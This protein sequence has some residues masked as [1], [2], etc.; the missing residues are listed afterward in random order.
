MKILDEALGNKGWQ[1]RYYEVCGTLFCDIGVYDHESKQ[2]IWKSD[3]GSKSDIEGEKGLA[4]DAFKRAAVV[5]GIG[6][7]LYTGPK[8]VIDLTEKDYFN[9]KLCQKFKV[10]ELT[11]T[12]GIITSL[13][14]VDKWGNQRYPTPKAPFQVSQ[15]AIAPPETRRTFTHSGTNP[16]M[17]CFQEFYEKMKKEPNIDLNELERFHVWYTS[18]DK[19]NPSKSKIETFKNPIPERMWENWMKNAR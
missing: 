5:W 14:I 4:S 15:V 13:V 8:P 6:R 7:E 17:A 3:T 11:V 12:D 19:M 9:G 16:P 1:R 18:P 10:K 2:W